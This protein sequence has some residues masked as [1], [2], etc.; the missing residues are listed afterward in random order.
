MYGVPGSPRL[1]AMSE[2]PPPLVGCLVC[3]EEGQLELAEKPS[4]FP[5]RSS[6][7]H[8]ICAHC[9]SV[10]LFDAN[11]SRPA[12]WRI[13][14]RR[15]S[16]GYPYAAFRF[17]AAG[18]IVA[19]EALDI[20]TEIYIQRQRLK[21]VEAG[22]LAWLKPTRLTPPP[23]LMSGD[24]T[25]YLALKPV[26]YYETSKSPARLPWLGGRDVAL[27]TGTCYITD[28]KIHLLGQ[29]RDRSHRLNEIYS[30]EHTRGVWRIYLMISDITHH[31]EGM[32]QPNGVDAELIAAVVEALR[33]GIT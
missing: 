31:Y 18:W 10:A 15:I 16:R 21:Q 14:Y 24:E 26:T 9:D 22:D 1:S 23:P 6:Y 5:L 30:V 17:L 13:K 28:T 2:L 11:P 32:G 4:R 12:N 25:V 3:H 19:D 8:L 20:S 27:D 33:E 7:P 29:R